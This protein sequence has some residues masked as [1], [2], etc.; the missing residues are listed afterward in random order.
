MQIQLKP[1]VTTSEFWVVIISGLLLTA[2]AALNLT[3]YTLAAGGVTLLGMLYAAMRHRLK[4]IQA[5][6]EADRLKAGM[7]NAE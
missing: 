7:T 6:A 4:T 2:Q 1:G 3:S 5:Q